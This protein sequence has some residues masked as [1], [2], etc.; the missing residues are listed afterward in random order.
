M[1][2]SRPE[3]SPSASAS[4]AKE[5]AP[6]M[7]SAASHAADTRLA[8]GPRRDQEKATYYESHRLRPALAAWYYRQI[9]PARRILDLGCGNGDFGRFR[10]S[11]V[12]EVHGIDVDRG[13]VASAAPHE[14]AVQGDLDGAM[15]PYEADFFDAVLARD[16]LEHL[17]EP[18]L[19]VR[20]VHRVL[21]PGG[22]I[23]ASVVMAKPQAVWADYTHIRGFTRGSVKLMFQDEGFEVDSIWRM[24]GIPLTSRL[25]LIGQVP[26]LLRLPLV[27]RRWA[28]SWEIRARRP[29]PTL[30]RTGDVRRQSRRT[31]PAR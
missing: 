26:W 3:P 24:G 29:D 19:T 27:G 13:A 11:T 23:V 21:R 12:M 7:S 5:S 15:L 25:G 18:W 28:T 1:S 6:L 31:L 8:T 16:I 22:V 10:P 17:R 2:R 20:E 30:L 9:G 14:I 4:V